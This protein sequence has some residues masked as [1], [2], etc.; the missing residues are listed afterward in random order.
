MAERLKWLEYSFNR[1]TRV[2]SCPFYMSKK[3]CLKSC[4]FVYSIG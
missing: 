1:V 2:L 3:G 4:V